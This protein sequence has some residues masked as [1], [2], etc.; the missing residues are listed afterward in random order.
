M[1]MATARGSGVECTL[2]SLGTSRTSKRSQLGMAFESC[3]GSEGFTEGD[4]GGNGREMRSSNY[5]TRRSDEL[6]CIGTRRT[7]STQGIQ[8]QAISGLDHADKTQRVRGLYPEQGIRDLARATEALRSSSRRG[9]RKTQ[10]TS[11]SSTNRAII[12]SIRTR[13]SLGSSSPRRCGGRLVAGM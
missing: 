5:A 12:T 8:D 2:R 3:R 13:S 7:A 9:G 11:K 4:D 1:H 6:N 10:A